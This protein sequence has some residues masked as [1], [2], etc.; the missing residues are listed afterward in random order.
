MS[1]GRLDYNSEGLIVL[2]NDG[3]LARCMELP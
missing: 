1:V 2:T 3:A